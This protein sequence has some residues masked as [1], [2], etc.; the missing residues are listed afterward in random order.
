MRNVERLTGATDVAITRSS[1]VKFI[2]CFLALLKF[3][4]PYSRLICRSM[5]LMPCDRA[6][7]CLRDPNIP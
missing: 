7:L 5:S 3:K 4:D 1:C 2:R 6:L